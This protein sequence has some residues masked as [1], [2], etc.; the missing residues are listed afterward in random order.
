V[1]S[2]S[3]GLKSSLTKKKGCKIASSEV[4]MRKIAVFEFARLAQ[5]TRNPARGK[6]NH[7]P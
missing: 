3:E 7:D 2:S 6:D 1:F 5:V 4:I